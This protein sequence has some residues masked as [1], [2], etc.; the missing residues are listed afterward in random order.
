MIE[1]GLNL[2]QE[3]I[4]HRQTRIDQVESFFSK[5]TSCSVEDIVQ[6]IYPDHVTSNPALF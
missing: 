2:V 3:Y 4:T 6:S 1:N 5:K